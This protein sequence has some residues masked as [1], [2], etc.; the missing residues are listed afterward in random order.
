MATWDKIYGQEALRRNRAAQDRLLVARHAAFDLQAKDITPKSDRPH[1]AVVGEGSRT[2]QDN[3]RAG[4]ERTFGRERAPSGA[5][6]A[7]QAALS[8][9]LAN[10]SLYDVFR[11]R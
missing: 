5:A 8:R 3:Y 6:L 9:R 10:P 11:G 2:A 1:F 7:L 4:W